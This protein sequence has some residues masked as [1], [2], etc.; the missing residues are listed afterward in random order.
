MEEQDVRTRA[1]AMCAALVT[2]DIGVATTDFSPELQRNLGEVLSLIPLPATGATIDAIDRG[3]GSGFI[4][5][6]RL[7]GESEEVLIQTRW[8]DRDDQPVVI[9]VSHLSKIPLPAAEGDEDAEADESP[10]GD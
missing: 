10:P 1:E 3:G 6:L 2:G 5:T 9:E 8:K 4:V 7:V